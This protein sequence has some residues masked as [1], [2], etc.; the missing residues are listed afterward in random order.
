[1]GAPAE[2]FLLVEEFLKEQ[3]CVK[4]LKAFQKE[5]KNTLKST[6]KPRRTLIE[7]YNT[8]TASSSSNTKD[9]QDRAINAAR[10]KERRESSSDSSS[11]EESSSDSSSDEESSSSSSSSEDSESDNDADSVSSDTESSSDD[12][13]SSSSSSGSEDSS[14]DDDSNNGTKKGTSKTSNT[15]GRKTSDKDI[16]SSSSKPES[17]SSDSSSSSSSSSS[18]SDSDSNSS[19]SSQSGTKSNDKKLVDTVSKT[20][21][22]PF[23]RVRAENVVFADEKLKDNTYMSKGGAENGYG[24]RAHLDMIVTRG[25]GFRAEKTKKKRGSYKGGFITNES[26]SFKFPDSD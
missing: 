5:A 2:L 16:D 26:H 25:K 15:S 23:K 17:E 12:E 21:N 24:Y 10:K 9:N 1:M 4:S 22:E 6:T 18:D 11:V 8:P 20:Q 3:G 14:D 19:S 13:E 7:L